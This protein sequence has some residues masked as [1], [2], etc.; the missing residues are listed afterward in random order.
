M[1][2]KSKRGALTSNKMRKLKVGALFSGIGGFCLAFETAGFDTAWACEIDPYA[3]AVY[4]RNFP[5]NRLLQKDVRELSVRGDRLEP[6]DVLHAGFPCQSFSQAGARSGFEDERGR[7]FFEIIRIV[8]EFKSQKPPVLVFENAPYLKMGEGGV[9]FAEIARQLQQAGYWFRESNAKELDLFDL[10]PIPQKRSRLFM[11][12][13]SQDHFR[14]GRFEF[15]GDTCDLPKQISKFIDF[16]GEKDDWYY[17]P[18]ENRYFK[19]ITG[20]KNDRGNVRHLYQLRKYFVRLKEPNV[21]PTLTANMGVADI[22]YL[23]YGTRRGCE[24]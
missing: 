19:M 16:E 15:P 2:S 14:D 8:N 4:R 18:E 9:W 1:H 11:V 10:T 17:L 3:C 20:Q 13:W 21:C 6:V 24:S 5:A 7:L 23:S 22:T 12:A